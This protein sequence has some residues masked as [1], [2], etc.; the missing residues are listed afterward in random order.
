MLTCAELV[1]VQHGDRACC[2]LLHETSMNAR[3]ASDV[4]APY[5][6]VRALLG[7]GILRCILADD[8]RS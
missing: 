1:R 6:L 7:G 5:V 2:V 4:T 8:I 3:N